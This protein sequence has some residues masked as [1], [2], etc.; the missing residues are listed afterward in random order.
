M[1]DV[2]TRLHNQL[3]IDRIFNISPETAKLAKNHP[4][5]IE[6][7]SLGCIAA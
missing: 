4:K 7:L 5:I 2:K 6:L 3:V 1:T